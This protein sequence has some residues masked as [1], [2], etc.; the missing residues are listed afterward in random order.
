MANWPGD[1]AYSYELTFSKQETGSVN[2]GQI[3]TSLHTGT[4][5]DA[6]FHFDDLGE[7]ILDLDVNL[8]VGKA[9]LIDVTASDTINIQSLKKHNLEGVERL[10]LRTSLLTNLAQFPKQI[11]K[12][13]PE[14][15][16][17]LAKKGVKLIGVNMPSV[18]PLD[19]KSL[20]THHALHDNGIHILENLVL[21]AINDGEYNLIALPLAIKDGDGSPV[22]AVIQ[23]I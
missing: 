5:V 1:T 16:P 8:Y 22:R 2:I 18:D 21:D 23:R 6:P 13:D 3:T 9:L 19:S 20:P 4:H 14:I 12:L 11:P 15:A 17:F 7:K 10:L